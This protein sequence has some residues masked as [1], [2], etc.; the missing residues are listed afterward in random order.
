MRVEEAD[1]GQSEIR[2]FTA[3]LKKV[4][5]Q[6]QKYLNVDFQSLITFRT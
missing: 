6:T 3:V 5:C 4:V 1:L 2:V